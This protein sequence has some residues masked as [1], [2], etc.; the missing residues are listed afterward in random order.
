[1]NK[2]RSV[3]VTG[4]AGFIGS[5]L[6]PRLLELGHS[7]TVLDNL[8]TGKLES[9]DDVLD[10]PKFVFQ[11]GDIRDKTIPNEV[12]DKIDSVIHLAALIDTSAS[13]A[14]PIQ[15][16][17]VNVNGTFN[18]LHAAIKHNVK[19]FV[20]ASSTAV[21]GDA[22]TLPLQENI[23][24][25]PISPYAASKVAGEAYCSAFASCFGLETIVLRFFNIYG[26]RSENNPYSGVI[27]KFLQKIIKGEV[28]T[29]DGDGEQTRDFIHVSD[30]IK[31]VILTL[32]H[33]GLKGEVFNVCTGVPT[34]IN[35][36]ATTLKTVT[37]KNPNVK[38]GPARLGDI[39]SSY[40]DLAK[41]KENLG[42]RASVD[43]TEGLQMLF[44]EFKK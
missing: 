32:E 16:H 21:Y 14:D 34:S 12:F 25:H 2:T 27:T 19:K 10:H 29:I 24:L 37:G 3:L 40:G 28:L 13:V 8:S 7:V 42:F 35:Q 44:E 39:R 11:R 1:M 17:E 36:L 38:Y 20:F 23:A 30:I 4:G 31:A 33:E 22:K 41:A 43:L 26:L 9:L 5:H 18:M 6:V 15:N